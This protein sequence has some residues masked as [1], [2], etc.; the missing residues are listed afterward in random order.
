[1]K[2]NIFKRI[3]L[4]CAAT[5]VSLFSFAQDKVEMASTMRSNGKIYVVV[6][7]CLL[8]LIGLFV[9]VSSIDRKVRRLEKEMK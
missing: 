6:T 9:Y 2:K 4:F 7:V 5:L 1:M 8:I 3:A